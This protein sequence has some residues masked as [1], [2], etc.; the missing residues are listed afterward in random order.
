MNKTPNPSNTFKSYETTNYIN[1]KSFLFSCIVAGLNNAY[2]YYEIS[3]T[4]NTII[5]LITT[6]SIVH[7]SLDLDHLSL[8]LKFHHIMGIIFC[9]ILINSNYKYE[10]LVYVVSNFEIS[11]IFLN[12]YFLTHNRFGQISF[13]LTFFYFRLYKYSE[14]LLFELNKDKIY[15][16]CKTNDLYN[17]DLCVG[18]LNLTSYTLAIM[19]TY[20]GLLIIKKI[21][22]II[23]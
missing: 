23:S 20:W 4:N 5:N 22:K 3:K 14:F 21:Y 7:F 1:F 17:I 19:N 15:L 18:I 6:I 16:I 9:S 12:Y 10:E 13:I 11:S 2:N 8:I